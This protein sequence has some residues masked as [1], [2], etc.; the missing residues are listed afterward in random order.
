[1]N[2]NIIGIDPG[3]QHQAFTVYNTEQQKVVEN[4]TFNMSLMDARKQRK[5]N[6][7]WYR[8]NECRKVFTEMLSK[9]ENPVGIVED[10]IYFGK[11]DE[12]DFA[13]MDRSPL[14][15]AESHGAL[16]CALAGLDIPC[17][18]VTASTI[19]FFV[20]GYG[21]ADKRA[22]IRAVFEAYNTPL[23]DEHQ[24]DALAC[25]HIG[26]YFVQYCIDPTA[27]PSDSYEANILS[28]ILTN[29]HNAGVQ[30][31]ILSYL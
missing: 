23:D 10:Y 8:L 4:I 20:T 1:M 18:K 27:F 22:M 13:H 31:R 2:I 15:L 11:M 29:R 28:K 26:R 21:A 6:P 7:S 25:A 3:R 24:F 14:Q 19:K 5:Y 9:Y 12:S 30:D 16:Y 17:V